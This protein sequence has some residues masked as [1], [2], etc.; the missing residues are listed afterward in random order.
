MT[1]DPKEKKTP[2]LTLVQKRAVDAS[3]EISL[4]PP[5]DIAYQHT[6]FCQTCLPYRDPGD[7]VREWKRQQGRVF[8]LIEAGQAY[9]PELQ[10]FVKVGLPFGPKARLI[11]A[12]LNGEALRQDSPLVQVENSLTAFV[13][14][15]QDPFKAGRSPTGPEIRKF[16][17]QLVRVSAS[18]MRLAV[19]V[20]SRMLQVN[21]QIVGAFDVWAGKEENQKVPWAGEIQ[22]SH[23]YFASLK[24]HAVPL[25][26]RALAA[27]SHSAMG[28]D[29]YVWLAQRLHRIP[30]NRPQ[31]VSWAALKVQF[32]QGY[33]RTSNFRRAFIQTLRLVYGQYQSARFEISAKGMTLYHSLPPV[34]PRGFVVKK[35]T[36]T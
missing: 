5:E 24:K 18:T 15:I 25:D 8:L 35:P 27:L 36:E 22:L 1:D 31:F 4:S 6:V 28:L 12:H 11:L 30:G 16:K 32:G 34:P 33:D 3:V 10:D 20:D 13:R 29:I 23:D 14:R 26:E 9:H 21:S 17:D 2:K 19:D 7:E